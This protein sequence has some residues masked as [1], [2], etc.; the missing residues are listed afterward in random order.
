MT[1]GN[2]REVKIPRRERRQKCDKT[3]DSITN[4]TFIDSHCGPLQIYGLEAPDGLRT[5][6]H[7]STVALGQEVYCYTLFNKLSTNYISC[8]KKLIK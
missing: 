8:I 7:K 3:I 5:R 4:D 1:K 2:N 6:V